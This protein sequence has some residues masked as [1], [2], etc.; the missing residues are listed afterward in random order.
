MCDS[1]KI[2]KSLLVGT[3]IPSQNTSLGRT[4]HASHPTTGATTTV[5]VQCSNVPSSSSTAPPPSMPDS[6]VSGLACGFDSLWSSSPLYNRIFCLENFDMASNNCTDVLGV[7]AP[8]PT[9]SLVPTGLKTE[10]GSQ[11]MPTPG[12]VADSDGIYFTRRTLGPS[13][14]G[15]PLVSLSDHTRP[16]EGQYSLNHTL[17]ADEAPKA[18]TSELIHLAV[19]TQRPCDCLLF[20]IKGC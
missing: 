19:R 11:F 9:K 1:A 13:T 12:P 7:A 20:V 16:H 17:I 14:V 15:P 4:V 6:G 18:E 8:L 5:I 2:T 3:I 10:Q